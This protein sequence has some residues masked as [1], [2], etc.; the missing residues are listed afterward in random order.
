MTI[1]EEKF[2]LPLSQKEKG[3]ELVK[4]Y[5]KSKTPTINNLE[6]PEEI[7]KDIEKTFK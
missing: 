2:F 1:W 6:T 4:I 5:R 3:S 7:L